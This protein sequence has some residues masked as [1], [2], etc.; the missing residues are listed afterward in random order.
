MEHTLVDYCWVFYRALEFSVL[1]HRPFLVLLG[2]TGMTQNMDMTAMAKINIWLH[3]ALLVKSLFWLWTVTS[4][5]LWILA[6]DTNIICL[7]TKNMQFCK[8]KRLWLKNWACHAHLKFKIQKGV[9]SS[10][11][12]PHPPNFG[13][14]RILYRW[15]NDIIT[16]FK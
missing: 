10:F 2:D 5:P 16:I 11:F 7:P 6:N 4:I 3:K 15:K 13:K 8:I 14:I 1:S 12:E 9:A